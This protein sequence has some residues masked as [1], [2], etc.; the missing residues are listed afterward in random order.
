VFF[1]GEYERGRGKEGKK[2]GG[3][4]NGGKKGRG[5]GVRG[6]REACCD[7]DGGVRVVGRPVYCGGVEAR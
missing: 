2:E 1:E 3:K 6:V 5:M 4:R 7:E